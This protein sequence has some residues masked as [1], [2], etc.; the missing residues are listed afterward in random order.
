M[1]RLSQDEFVIQILLASFVTYKSVWLEFLVFTFY[2]S[3]LFLDQSLVFEPF[4][5]NA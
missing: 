5:T 2:L 3:H 1:R 4:Q